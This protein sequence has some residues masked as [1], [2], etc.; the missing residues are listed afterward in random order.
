M[1]KQFSLL[2]LL[3]ITAC[4][5]LPEEKMSFSTIK[6]FTVSE[7][8]STC[9]DETLELSSSGDNFSCEISTTFF[10]SPTKITVK[11]KNSVIHNINLT[12]GEGELNYSFS[13]LEDELIKQYGDPTKVITKGSKKGMIWFDESD[14]FYT[15]AEF[16]DSKFY[17]KSVELTA[18]VA[19]NEDEKLKIKKFISPESDM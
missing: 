19:K 6:G 10:N 2:S 13:V 14:G 18:S 4:S 12:L 8:L 17:G 5:E 7:R 1:L 9:P 3:I 16:H 11:V 15:T